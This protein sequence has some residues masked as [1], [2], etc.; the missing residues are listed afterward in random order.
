MRAAGTFRLNYHLVFIANA[1]EQH[2]IGLEEID[3][4]VWSIYFNRVLLARL[5]ERNYILGTDP[6]SPWK[7]YPCSR[8]SMLPMFPIVQR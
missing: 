3:D 8:F 2:C 6:D 1:L 5:D 4:G 7:C